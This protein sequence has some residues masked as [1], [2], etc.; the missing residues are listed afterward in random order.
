MNKIKIF[1]L[2]GGAG[3]FHYGAD[4]FFGKKN[5]EC[6]AYGEIDK[7]ARKTY[8]ANWPEVK[9]T[10]EINDIR[11]IT[12]SPQSW[13]MSGY[14]EYLDSVI[15]DHDILF[16]GFPCQP[17]SIMGKTKGFEDERGTLFFH[18]QQI[19]KHKEPN[20][21]ILENVQRLKTLNGGKC[22]EKICRILREE[23]GYT[24]KVLHL[25]SED[26]GVPQVR[27]R[28]FFVGVKQPN[29]TQKTKLTNDDCFPQEIDPSKRE[30][31]TVLDLL[32]KK[33]EL[34]NKLRGSYCLSERI[35][36]TILSRGTG[37][38]DAKPEINKDPARPLTKTMH[39]MHR[40]SQDN[41]YS[42]DFI[43]GT[44][45]SDG[46][47]ELAKT[48]SNELRR[49]TPEEAFRLQGF[50]DDFV[51]KA[52]EA[53]VSDTQLYMQ[54][55]NAVTATVISSILNW[56]KPT[57]KKSKEEEMIKK[58]CLTENIHLCETLK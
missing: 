16:A 3:G 49:I 33:D 13:D 41:Y 53:G 42:E 19:I 35:K 45:R 50:K 46:S 5:V 40:A 57:P 56:I 18:I 21:F 32:Q 58:F 36:K 39:K 4:L 2:F 30:Y 24:M 29:K 31:P 51:K 54:A 22:Y 12:K 28:I 17:F 55:G 10:K 15:P 34:P 23:L 20:Y 26:Y 9:R 1:D 37:G 25:N 11:E 44:K 47:I 27:R 52:R 14:S 8:F 7:Y 43:N 6:V 38:W 48:G